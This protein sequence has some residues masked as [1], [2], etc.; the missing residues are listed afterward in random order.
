MDWPRTNLVP[1]A[2]Q[3]TAKGIVVFQALNAIRLNT[4]QQ[5]ILRD[6]PAQPDFIAN[7]PAFTLNAT[8]ATA[9]DNAL[10]PA[11]LATAAF[12]LSVTSPAF[13]GP[14]QVLATRPLSAGVGQPSPKDFRPIALLNSLPGTPIHLAD[15]YLAQ[16]PCA[17][18]LGMKVALQLVPLTPNGFRGTPRTQTVIATA[19]PIPTQSATLPLALPAPLPQKPRNQH[20]PLHRHD[21]GHKVEQQLFQWQRP[22]MNAHHPRAVHP[23]DAM[24]QGKPITRTEIHRPNRHHRPHQTTPTPQL[25]PRREP[26]NNNHRHRPPQFIAQIRPVPAYQSL[27]HNSPPPAGF[28]T[29]AKPTVSKHTRMPCSP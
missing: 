25:P 17:P 24:P 19:A 9:P 28:S 21:I 5:N 6:A 16:F 12:A 14:V 2:R 7:L 26:L 15:A 10:S 3:S 13:D 23:P 22:R 8:H 18:A 27:H 11:Q 20:K 29:R 1:H 4:G